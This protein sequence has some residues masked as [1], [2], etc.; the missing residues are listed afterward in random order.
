MQKA[1]TYIFS[2]ILLFIYTGRADL[3]AQKI[4]D[5]ENVIPAK[6]RWSVRTNALE[7]LLTIPNVGFE[8]DLCKSVYNRMTLGFST[9]YN[10]NTAHNYTTPMVFNLFEF[11]PEF[12]YYWRQTQKPELGPNDTLSFG[13]WF[14]RNIWT[15]DSKNPKNWRAY[16]IGAYVNAGTYS[17]KLGREG[18][19]GQ[20]YGLGLT[21]GYAVPL[22]KYDKSAVDVEFGFS[23]G[24]ALTKYNAF[25]HNQNGNYYYELTGRSRGL[26]IVPYPVISELK[27]AFVYRLRSVDDK[28]RK[29]DQEKIR[30]KQEEDLRKQQERERLDAEKKARRD[31]LDR[32]KERRLEA[33]AAEKAA[34]AEGQP[35]GSQHMD[36][37]QPE[38]VGV[39]DAVKEK[40][41]GLFRKKKDGSA[42]ITVTE[43]AGGRKSVREKPSDE[44]SGEVK[45]SSE[46]TGSGKEKKQVWKNIFKAKNANGEDEK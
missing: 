45:S 27:V 35:D 42:E 9:K 41:P 2:V 37:G 10:W 25:G 14:K 32:A 23:L 11:R 18:H 17:F 24:L 40:R 43:D 36:A 7:W 39:T 15:T 30:Q 22:Y 4:D 13:Q 21:L 29:V 12:R 33:K 8:Y 3:R 6:E 20:M 44:L 1:I 38:N 28:Y 46:D 26:H 19:Q 16:Y 5:P 34:A 31:S